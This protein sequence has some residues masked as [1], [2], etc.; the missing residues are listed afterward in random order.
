LALLAQWALAAPLERLVQW[1]QLGLKGLP[2]LVSL[3]QLEF[4]EQLEH[5][6]PLELAIRA[7]LACKGPL[8][9]LAQQG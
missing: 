2:A 5:K 3:V 4:K 8:G 6:E 1:E 9:P 7:L